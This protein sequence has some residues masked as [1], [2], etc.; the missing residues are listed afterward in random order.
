MPVQFK[1]P[2][3]AVSLSPGFLH[4]AH[5][6]KLQTG[7]IHRGNY[8]HRYFICAN[9]NRIDPD[10]TVCLICYRF[11]PLFTGV[12]P[13]A[14]AKVMGYEVGFRLIRSALELE[15]ALSLP[16]SAPSTA[17]E[18]VP[19]PAPK[20]KS[21]LNGRKP[22]PRMPGRPRRRPDPG[23]GEKHCS[24]PDCKNPILPAT[25]EYFPKNRCTRDGLGYYCKPCQSEKQA[26]SYE[27]NKLKN[28]EWVE[29]GP[30]IGGEVEA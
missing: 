28:T 6:V 4:S 23:P 7:Q 21:K 5:P 3:K 27:K 13:L 10:Q 16:T 25:L 20:S 30:P 8:C 17:P 19:V 1:N 14:Q 24:N 9:Q 29:T 15:A 18:P 26:R 11:I 22:K 12:D 2:E